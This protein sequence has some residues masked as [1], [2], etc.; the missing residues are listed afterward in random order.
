MNF[1]DGVWELLRDSP[2]LSPLDFSQRFTSTSS[3]DGN[4]IRGCWESSSD[5]SNW[6]HDF[7]LTYTNVK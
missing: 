4:T 1:S 2:D 3:E 5:G 7:E 6:T